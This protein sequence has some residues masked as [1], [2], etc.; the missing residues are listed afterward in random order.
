MWEDEKNKAGGRWTIKVPKSHS[1]KYWE[2][3]VLSLIGEQF[4][5]ADEINGVV[6]SLRPNYDTI[7]VWN[8]SAKDSKKVESI[9]NDIEKILNLEESIKLEYD[10]FAEILSRPPK[11]KEARPERNNDF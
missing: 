1:N 2:D 7:S 6:I 8:R 5:V 3:L 11:E 10:D 4:E 9:K